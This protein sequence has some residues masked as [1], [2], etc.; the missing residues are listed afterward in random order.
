MIFTAFTAASLFTLLSLAAPAPVHLNEVTKRAFSQLI[1][2][3]RDNLCLSIEGGISRYGT[4]SNGTT[5]VD[6]YNGLPVVSL[7]CNQA[8]TWDINP[9]S[10][11]VLVAASTP[12]V[13]RFA[14][15][16]GSYPGNGGALKVDSSRSSLVLCSELTGE[17]GLGIVPWTLPTNVSPSSG[18]FGKLRVNFKTLN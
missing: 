1:Y 4:N 15:D 16:A 9:G 6:L 2:A 13:P 7:P 3:G 14:L 12:T 18:T 17:V 11:S 8:S 10:G 5:S